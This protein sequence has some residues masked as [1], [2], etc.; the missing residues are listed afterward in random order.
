V[1]RSVGILP[2]QAGQPANFLLRKTQCQI[3]SVKELRIEQF[4]ETEGDSCRRFMPTEASNETDVVS[5]A[6]IELIDDKST[7]RV[8]VVK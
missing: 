6:R 1:K 7:E 4:G 2:G 5:A 3:G 8:A